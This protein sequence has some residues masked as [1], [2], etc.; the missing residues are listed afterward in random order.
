[1]GMNRN[2]FKPP[3]IEMNHPIKQRL[4]SPATTLIRNSHHET[5]SQTEITAKNCHLK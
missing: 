2:S 1:M 5:T 3:Q 4:P